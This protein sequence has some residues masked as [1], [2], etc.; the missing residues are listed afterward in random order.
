VAVGER[1]E[2]FYSINIH[3]STMAQ[4]LDGPV[5]D[6]APSTVTLRCCDHA[7]LLCARLESE[8][9]P[10]AAGTRYEV[11]AML[12]HEGQDDEERLHARAGCDEGGQVL[13]SVNRDLSNG[14][15]VALTLSCLLGERLRAGRF[16]L[17]ETW[18]E[19]RHVADIGIVALQ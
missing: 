2:V 13:I 12:G 5:R 14:E 3:A 4:V 15:S 16:K 19:A 7:T 17:E 1:M 10:V 11:E 18:M 9:Q 6:G 8:G